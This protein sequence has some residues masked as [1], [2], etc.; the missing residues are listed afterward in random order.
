MDTG[1]MKLTLC[2]LYPELL[3]LYGDRGNLLA[4]VRRLRLRGIGVE[5]RSVG[6]GDRFDPEEYDLV[7]LGGGQ[8]YEQAILMD[9]LLKNKA[10]AIREAVEADRVFLC[11]CGGFQLMGQYYRTAEGQEMRFLGAMDLW[12]I[13]GSKRLIGNTVYRSDVLAAE[14]QDPWIVGFENHSGRTW[15][16]PAVQPL[17]KVVRGHG[18]NGVDG[19]EGAVYRNVVCTYSH[20]SVLPKNPGLADLLLRRAV[21]R[22]Y[23]DVGPLPELDDTYERRAQDAAFKALSVERETGRGR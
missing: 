5:V 2:H 18:N 6:I 4:L 11:I 22:R 9:D 1:S 13:G 17:A 16:G 12:T 14:G 20:G 10:N 7:F 15:L 3:N 8:D 19:T 23:G 21:A